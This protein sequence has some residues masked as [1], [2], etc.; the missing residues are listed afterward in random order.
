MHETVYII[1]IY[2]LLSIKLYDKIIYTN[3]NVND[4]PKNKINEGQY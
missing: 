4:D 2:I 3:N 1:Y